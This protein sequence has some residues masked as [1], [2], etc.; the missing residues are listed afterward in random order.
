MSDERTVQEILARY[1]RAVDARHA[2]NVAALYAPQG[3]ER[4][5][6]NRAGVHEQLA[7]FT[8]SQAI[9]DAV[10]SLLAPHPL[11][12]WT[13]HATFDPIVA[14]QGDTA[15]I[16]AQFVVLEVRGARRPAAG[17]PIGASGGQGTIAPIESGCYQISLERTV[18]GWKM[19]ENHTIL[20]LPSAM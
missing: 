8:G 17:W 18:D 11:L 7:V 13:R 6:Y 12:G 10:S 15:S 9:R 16:D 3:V 14:V 4:F 2:D 19:I 1:V 20:D 5:S